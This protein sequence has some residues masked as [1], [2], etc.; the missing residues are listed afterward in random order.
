M[1][2]ANRLE[3]Y[4]G[5]V[6]KGTFHIHHSSTVL[7]ADDEKL[8]A[9]RVKT[10]EHTLLI[11]GS[12][13]TD[14]AEWVQAIQEAIDGAADEAEADSDDEPDLDEDMED[15]DAVDNVEE[16][17]GEDADVED[18]ADE[19]EDLEAVDDADDA[20]SNHCKLYS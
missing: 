9:F 14:Q 6:L 17:E 10:H 3:Y 18:D 20:S 12:S 8:Y 4:A 7:K 15:V 11:K 13:A 19:D 16:E 2:L 5:T 1:L